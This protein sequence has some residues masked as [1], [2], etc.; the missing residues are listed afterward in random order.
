MM[1]SNEPNMRWLSFVVLLTGA[2]TGLAAEEIYP[3]YEWQSVGSGIYLH[4]QVDP[5]AGPVDGNSVVIFNSDGVLVVD[6]HINP[7]VA[8]AVVG[9]IRSMTDIPVTHVVNTHWHDDHTNG[10]YVYRR[11]FPDVKIIAHQATLGL[12]REEW[13]AMEDQR[14]AAYANVDLDELQR[15]ASDPG[16]AGP[17]AAISYD[18]YGGYVAALR[19]ELPA[20][21]LEYPDT[22][23]DD[24]LAL[25]FENRRVELKWLGRGNT[26]GDAVVWLPHERILITG[27]LLV[28][29]IPF[30]F[31]SPMS[32]WI[33]TLQH[34]A[35]MD[36]EVIIP[37]HGAVQ[38]GDRYLLLVKALLDATIDAVRSAREAGVAFEELEAAVNL[39]EF[40]SQFA[41][42]DR[43]RLWAWRSYFV[44]PGL[45]SAWLSLGYPLPAD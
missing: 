37:G 28:A 21:E 1:S 40:R 32:D 45:K 36:V 6:T 44:S 31:D 24:V 18:V 13:A 12:L 33:A 23:F 10:N 8:R 5:L 35:D 34:L 17:D 11:A 27:D 3:G 15:I 14:R 20:L 38:Y 30:A 16:P 22:V 9:K 39:D 7:A 2:T 19:P 43:L 29:P 42:E 41:G 25:E 4:S 26:D